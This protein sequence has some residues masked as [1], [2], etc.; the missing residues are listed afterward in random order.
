MP[1]PKKVWGP[2]AAPTGAVM[3]LGYGLERVAAKLMLSTVGTMLVVWENPD[4]FT[5]ARRTP[6][7]PWNMPAPRRST[8]WGWT[9]Q[10]SPARGRKPFLGVL[11]RLPL[12]PFTPANVSPPMA[13]I[14]GICEINEASL[15]AKL[16][17]AVAEKGC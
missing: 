17:A 10:A 12:L 4:W 16:A 7:K 3:P 2:P 1:C 9:C 14:D 13:D 6:R 8:V 11:Y 5:A 15:A